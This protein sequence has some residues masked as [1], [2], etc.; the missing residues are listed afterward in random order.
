[1]IPGREDDN[2]VNCLTLHITPRGAERFPVKLVCL[3]GSDGMLDLIRAERPVHPYHFD[4]PCL[5]PE[6]MPAG[7]FRK[8]CVMMLVE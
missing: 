7:A 2:V 5:V 3:T 1:M 8:H 4:R 6:R